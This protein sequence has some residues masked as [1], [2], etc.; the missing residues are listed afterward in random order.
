[1]KKVLLLAT[2]GVAGMMNAYSIEFSDEVSSATMAGRTCVGVESDC[3]GGGI[4]FA[5]GE[6]NTDGELDHEVV[7][8]M[9]QNLNEAFCGYGE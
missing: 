1:M 8:E 2:F 9:R 4:W 7:D 6:K 5:C 3:G